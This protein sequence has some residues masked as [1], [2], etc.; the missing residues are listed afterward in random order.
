MYPIIECLKAQ[1]PQNPLRARPVRAELDAMRGANVRQR[2]A[3]I[4]Y[5]NELGVVVCSGM[6][7]SLRALLKNEGEPRRG[8]D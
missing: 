2:N 3:N 5:T 8:A 6:S 4:T 7:A 1:L